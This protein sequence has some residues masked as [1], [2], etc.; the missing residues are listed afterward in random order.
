MK[1]NLKNIISTESYV[2]RNP[3]EYVLDHIHLFSFLLPKEKIYGLKSEIGDGNW[4][5]SSI[6][7]GKI[8]YIGKIFIDDIEVN[9]KYLAS[10]SQVIYDERPYKKF[11]FSKTNINPNKSCMY[12]F[13]NYDKNK[14]DNLIKRLHITDKMNKPLKTVS[15]ERFR[16]EVLIGIIQDKKIF[17]FPF[18]KKR[19][20]EEKE[21]SYIRI[22]E[23][24]RSLKKFVFIPTN[25]KKLLNLCDEIIDL[26]KIIKHNKKLCKNKKGLIDINEFE[27]NFIN[28]G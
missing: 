26:E 24:L 3:Y 27:K 21:I 7:C 23:V 20:F 11:N 18:I 2:T 1:I 28:N 14:L 25:N 22:I 12:Y 6:L 10:I 8:N 5:I 13:K 17:C 9:K 4:A 19:E 16:Q 15:G